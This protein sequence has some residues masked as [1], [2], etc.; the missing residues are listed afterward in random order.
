MDE[1]N[2]LVIKAGK[3]SAAI[4]HKPKLKFRW[5]K[6]KNAENVQNSIAVL[7]LRR[8]IRNTTHRLTSFVYANFFKI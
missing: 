8:R 3:V 7:C 2:K 5:E 1:C 4:Y 6:Q